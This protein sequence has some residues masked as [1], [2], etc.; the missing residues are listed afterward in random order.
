MTVP[1]TSTLVIP[2]SKRGG[3]KKGAPKSH[4]M[5]RRWSDRINQG[6]GFEGEKSISEK[7]NLEVEVAKMIEEGY[8]RGFFSKINVEGTS[9]SKIDHAQT[10]LEEELKLKLMWREEEELKSLDGE[11][12]S[13]ELKLKLKWTEEEPMS[14]E[15]VVA[16]LEEQ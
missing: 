14:S 15:L 2:K 13:E 16:S 5:K 7:W 8:A 1:S 6:Y 12:A 10:L 11:T 3:K 9:G 4:S